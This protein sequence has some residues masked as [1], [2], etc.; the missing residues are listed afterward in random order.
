MT[1]REDE[2]KS[3]ETLNR[4]FIGDSIYDDKYYHNTSLLLKLYSKVKWR[5]GNSIIDLDEEC[6]KSYGSSIF[7]TIDMLVD[8]DPRVNKTRLESRLQSIENSKSI[9]VLID[10]ALVIL[11]KYPIE[12]DKYFEILHK[13]YLD[14]AQYS[15][16]E[17]L[18]SINISRST[19]FRDKK[20][21]INLLSVVLWG[22]V[23]PD[24][25]KSQVQ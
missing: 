23:I 4:I 2:T 10:R 19:Y 22:F 16:S 25:K 21:A 17:I 9:L 14:F 20:K 24:I 11:K 5:M 6:N 13:R 7:E 3:L 12:G 18:E 15:E 8:V 1:V